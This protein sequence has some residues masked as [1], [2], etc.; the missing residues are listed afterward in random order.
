MTGATL[1]PQVRTTLL[2]RIVPLHLYAGRTHVILERSLLAYQRSWLVVLTGF[3]EPVF[4]LLA[5]GQGLGSLIGQVSTVAGPV[6]YAA[7]IAPGLLAT[8][9]MNG[10]IFD[11]TINVFFKLKYAKLYDGMLAASLGPVDVALGEIVWSLIRGG[12]YSVAFVLVMLVMG[13]LASW[14]ALLAV[15]VALIVAFG[16][17]AVGMAI[18]TFMKTFQQMDWIT[19]ALLPM[20]LFSTTFY[21]LGVYPRAVQILVECL[22]LY[23]GIELI[24]GLCLGLVSPGLFLHL[25]YFA[26]MIGVGVTVASRRLERL[27]LR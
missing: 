17:A 13:L 12:L 8:S 19:T 21:P 4:Y 22:P 27:L 26:G 11:S 10:A 20:F 1:Q 9:A 15:P 14:W 7:Y 25:L 16:F 23:H 24:R 2:L 6:A 5:M 3:F 18:T